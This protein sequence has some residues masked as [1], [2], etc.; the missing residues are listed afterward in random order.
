LLIGG[1]FIAVGI[2]HF[3]DP[4]FF[5][6][7]VPR[8][9][10]SPSF[11]NQVSG[12]LEIGLGAALIPIWTRRYAAWGLLAL[13][14]LVYPANIDMF[15]NNVDVVTNEFGETVRIED[16]SGV[17]ARNLIRLPF[18]FVF[19]WLILRHARNPSPVQEES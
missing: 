16:A 10:W 18:Q 13:L 1:A 2:N 6:A 19:A 5:E 15:I 8:W 14:V 11:A 3:T 17:F 9:F 4:D 7:I 12:A